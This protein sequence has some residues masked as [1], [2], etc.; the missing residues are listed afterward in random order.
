MQNLMKKPQ[1]FIKEEIERFYS[2]YCQEKSSS[3]NTRFK[4][5]EYCHD[6]FVKNRKAAQTDEALLD[7]MA[8]H[9]A[10]YLASWGMYRGSSFLLQRDYKCH[11]PV[12]KEVLR[13]CYEPL[14]DFDPKN[15][16]SEKAANLLFGEEALY[17]K[18]KYAYAYKEKDDEPEMDVATDTLVTKILMGVF[19]CMPAFDSYLKDG[20]KD[21][22]KVYSVDKKKQISTSFDSNNYYQKDWKPKKRQNKLSENGKKAFLQL[23]QFAVTYHDAFQCEDSRYPVMKCMDMFFWQYGYD[24]K[25]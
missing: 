6:F 16:D 23:C 5:W 18:I 10:F 1:D 2:T 15:G 12:V 8:L 14:W 4:S 25:K 20:I 24:L 22:Q 17:L 3:P 7:H 9:L 13:D 19:G 11:I 21:F